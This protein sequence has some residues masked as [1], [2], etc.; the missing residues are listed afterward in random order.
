MKVSVI[1]PC[2]NAGPALGRCLAA[3]RRQELGGGHALEVIVVDDG[4]TDGTAALVDGLEPGLDLRYVHQPRTAAS[5]RSAARNIGIG[6]ATGD[7]VVMLDPDHVFPPDFVARHAGHHERRPDLVVLGPRHRLGDADTGPEAFLRDWSFASLP[8]PRDVRLMVLARL[9]ADLDDLA[10]CWHY[11]FSCN[12]SVR[13]EHL[14]AVG[15]FDVGFAG[16]GLEDSELGY[17]LRRHGLAFVF[18]PQAVLYTW[19]RGGMTARRYADWRRNL[20]HFTATHP[21]ADVAQ[22]WLLD[23]TFNPDVTVEDGI[24]RYVA[25]EHAV[26]ALRG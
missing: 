6:H 12:L 10:T 24:G 16:W 22:L 2:Y 5:G 17:R 19:E 11:A 3:L 18:E 26:R 21:G 7:L 4:S 15:G 23:D 9:G 1:L 25:F 8:P 13:R 14:L 20:V